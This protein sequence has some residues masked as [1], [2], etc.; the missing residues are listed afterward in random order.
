MPT[1]YFQVIFLKEIFK[2]SLWDR[3]IRLSNSLR[4]DIQVEHRHEIIL[5]P[6][7]I[8]TWHSNLISTSSESDFRIR[9]SSLSVIIPKKV[10]LWS[11]QLRPQNPLHLLALPRKEATNYV[12]RASG[13]FQFNEWLPNSSNSLQSVQ[14]AR[15]L[16]IFVERCYIRLTCIFQVCS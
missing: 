15:Y 10:K 13:I 8:W 1:I 9:D 12:H 7:Y 4:N 3:L 6:I 5:S 2:L 14:T 16:L 11:F